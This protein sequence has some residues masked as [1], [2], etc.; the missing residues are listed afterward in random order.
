MSTPTGGGWS[1]WQQLEVEGYAPAPNEQMM[2]HRATVAPGYFI[3]GHPDARRPR[4]HRAGRLRS[5]MVMVVNETFARR[6]SGGQSHWRKVRMGG[7]P[8]TVVGLVKAASTTP[9]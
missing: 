9:R 1:P 4:F 3:S 5:A 8:T 2:I 6:F 7:N